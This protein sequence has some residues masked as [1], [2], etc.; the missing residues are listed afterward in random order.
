[1][2][3]FLAL[4]P[5]SALVKGGVKPKPA[6]DKDK[7]STILQK[8]QD[9]IAGLL[10]KDFDVNSANESGLTLLH[11][12]SLNGHHGFAE[13]LLFIGADVQAK[14]NTGNTALHLAT[15]SG[16]AVVI[17]LLLDNGAQVNDINH[18]CNTPL[19]YAAQYGK[20]KR[21]VQALM[22]GGANV[23]VKNRTNE[24]P[25]DLA[26]R[27]GKVEM[28]QLL[29]TKDQI[30]KIY[31]R[32]QRPK[33]SPFHLA[34]R[35]GHRDV[36]EVLLQSGV[37]IDCL[38]AEGNTALH[39]ATQFGKKDVVLFLL[40]SGANANIKNDVGQTPLELFNTFNS[41]AQGNVIQSLLTASAQGAN[42]AKFAEIAASS[43]TPV[44]VKKDT[45]QPQLQAFAASGKSKTR[46]RATMNYAGSAYD[47]T[48]LA[49]SAGDII[50]IEEK[51]ETGWWK[52][53]LEKNGQTGEF[54]SNFVEVL[55]DDGRISDKFDDS[56]LVIPHLS[57][58]SGQ[59]MPQHSP[60]TAS[61]PTKPMGVGYGV[62][63][64]SLNLN[65][66]RPVGQ[67]SPGQP[68]QQLTSFPAKFSTPPSHF[69]TAPPQYSSPQPQ[70]SMPPLQ[71]YSSS[72][73]ISAIKLPPLPTMN[74]PQSMPTV[75]ANTTLDEWLTQ[76]NLDFYLSNFNNAGFVQLRDVRYM[77]DIQLEMIGIF[78]PDHRKKLCQAIAKVPNYGVPAN[79][80][81]E[82]SKSAAAFDDLLSDFDDSPPSASALPP[83]PSAA[84]R[85]VS[86]S[87]G[88]APLPA[89]LTAPPSLPPAQVSLASLPKP[90]PSV[91]GGFPPASTAAQP[92]PVA[93]PTPAAQPPRPA[94]TT[95]APAPAVIAKPA[96]APA[97][98]A[99]VKSAPAAAPPPAEGEIS[100]D[101]LLN[102]VDDIMA[103]L[104]SELQDL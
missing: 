49:F 64:A 74:D 2:Q 83:P 27:F 89:P 94:F 70:V 28:V 71:Q 20:D 22:E 44:L 62:S 77:D 79:L 11:V 69:A 25:V 6:A 35:S 96:P 56:T 45:P 3:A 82:R 19:H 46:A 58:M 93:K 17:R 67:S 21:C 38:N 9:G 55:A 81:S 51:T 34:A 50:L 86:S 14:D 1:V 40:Q 16:H 66:L 100:F 104:Q 60:Y 90:P 61:L 23:V 78:V 8:A 103:D 63:A 53:T 47:P 4:V 15:W 91:G 48:V 99:V 30:G 18:E 84:K 41:R 98:A 7:R 57:T 65:A 12:A 31:I 80:R 87:F 13:K 102:D 39:E 10:K 29:A 37:P 95:P 59:Q 97:P 88:G 52:G 26:A 85:P 36:C 92:P 54:K 72:P 73:P 33:C 101:D 24:T 32:N 5:E 68:V 43:A 75:S 42:K 76:M